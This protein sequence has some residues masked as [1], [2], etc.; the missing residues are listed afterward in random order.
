M[1]RSVGWFVYLYSIFFYVYRSNMSGVLQTVQYFGYVA[2]IAYAF[3][4]ALGTVA[5]FASQRFV[6]YIYVSVK[7]D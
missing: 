3:F 1:F 2:V 4:L 7:T 6:K 5:F